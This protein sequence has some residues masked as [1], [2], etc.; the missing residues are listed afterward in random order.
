MVLALKSTQWALDL[1]TKLVKANV[2]VHNIEAIED[3]HAIVFVVNHFTRL[4][5]FLLPYVVYTRT[6]REVWSLGAAQLFTGRLG[7]YLQSMGTVSTKDPDRDKT[8]INGLLAGE[9]PWL[10]F[11]EGRMVKDKKVVDRR[12]RFSV[13]EGQERRAPHTGAAV[14]AL[15]AE[16]YRRELARLAEAPEPDERAIQDVLSR[17][18]LESAEQA[19][20]RHTVII[21]VNISYFPVR[22][23]ENLFLRLA[24]RASPDLSPRALEELSVEGTVLS[25]D[26]DIDITFGEPIHIGE[27]QDALG[28]GAAGSETE[29]SVQDSESPV[30][31]TAQGVMAR[32]MRAIYR[33]TVVNHDDV[34]ASLVRFQRA[35]R[36][37]PRSF[38]Q[39]AFLAAH[40]LATADCC[41]LHDEL[42]ATHSHL[43][44]G[45][46]SERL[47]DFLALCQ[48]EGVY[49][50]DG[51]FYVKRPR[52]SEGTLDF[53]EVRQQALTYVIAN[54]L[55]PLSRASSI[56]RSV[57]RMSE[58]VLSKTIRNFFLRQDQHFFEDAYAQYAIEGESKPRAVGR[59]FL[60]TPRQIR[61]GV[62]LVHG[63]MAAPLEVRP[64]AEYLAHLGYA[65]YGVRLPG[66]GTAPEDLAQTSWE[67]WLDCVGRG[68]AILNTL[69]PKV[70]LGGFS[71]GGILALVAAARSGDA[72]RGV[73]AINAPYELRRY[74]AKLASSIV[75]MNQLL[76]R[77]SGNEEPWY[78]ENAPENTHINYLRNPVTG[79]KELGNAM[80]A[81]K[82]ELGAVCVPSL[83]VQADGDTVVHPDSGQRIFEG[84]CAHD[85]ELIM[86]HRDHH[87][88]I[89]GDGAADVFDHVARFLEDR[90]RA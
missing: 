78:V 21:P 70:H 37:S 54:E 83:V 75:T 3:D 9:H 42:R 60:L 20:S 82:A 74:T 26:T 27:Y 16:F 32:Y 43:A 41:R 79:V 68:C 49:E 62:V 66:H 36:I 11:P 15:R 17:F 47:D 18:G 67:D 44:Y 59:P 61:G 84:L 12:H 45:F 77:L 19:L 22:S 1:A 71:M 69:T 64:M 48:R 25:A 8:I 76:N 5:T 14:L 85:K 34:L 30:H 38:R 73:F 13:Y 2:R 89:N 65:V 81:M 40:R 86:V 35:R 46:R 23:G 7:R 29:V 90:P 4:E 39:R 87:G 51:E 31:R 6:G 56:I 58:R 88:I 55:E 80:N 24:K 33:L 53:H 52:P 10:I 72:V 50:Q 63:Y 28:M 57:A